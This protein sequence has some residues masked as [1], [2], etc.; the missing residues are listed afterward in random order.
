MNSPSLKATGAGAIVRFALNMSREVSGACQDSTVSSWVSGLSGFRWETAAV[1]RGLAAS[2][3][4]LWFEPQAGQASL[5][6]AI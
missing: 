1:R 3:L 2:R 5:D 4:L 6:M